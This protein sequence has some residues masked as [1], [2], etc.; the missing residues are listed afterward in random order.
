MRWISIGLRALHSATLIYVLQQ[1]SEITLGVQ[2]GNVIYSAEFARGALKQ[3]NLVEGSQ[4]KAEVKG[5]KMTVHR[6]DGKSVTARIIW[7]RDSSPPISL[8]NQ[9]TLLLPLLFS[10]EG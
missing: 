7:Y 9:R 2:V 10:R 3:E 5:G 8:K 1:D 6:R 4:I